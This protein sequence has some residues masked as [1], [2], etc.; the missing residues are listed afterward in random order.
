MSAWKMAPWLSRLVVLA[1]AILFS[2]IGLKFIIDPHTAAAASGITLEAGFGYT[3]TRAGFGGFPLGFALLL[4]LS[5]FWSR[6]LPPALVSIATVTAVIL[7]VRIFG[8]AQDH[9]LP[10]SAHLLVPEAVITIAS[11]FA[12]RMEQAYRSRQAG[13]T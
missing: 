11:L 3:N 10:Q 13:T 8:A 12:L 9:T 1:V 7:V 2:T 5:L 6:W 4:F